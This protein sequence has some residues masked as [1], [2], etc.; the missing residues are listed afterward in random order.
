MAEERAEQAAAEQAVAEQASAEQ[1][2]PI[3]MDP[4]EHHR[5]HHS[6][7]KAAEPVLAMNTQVELPSTFWMQFFRRTK[8]ETLPKCKEFRAL[9][10]SRSGQARSGSACHCPATIAPRPSLVMHCPA[11]GPA[12]TPRHPGPRR[13]GP[14]HCQAM[15]PRAFAEAVMSCY[16]LTPRLAM[17]PRPQAP[18]TPCST[19]CPARPVVPGHARPMMLGSAT[20]AA[21]PMM[22]PA[23]VLARQVL[24]R[25]MLMLTD[26][27]VWPAAA[28]HHP[29]DRPTTPLWRPS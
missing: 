20:M 7:A 4:P 6:Q 18:M 8:H 17:T 10:V 22:R 26:R 5:P 9:C 16:A 19:L 1:A 21:K 28:A 3:A 15:T 12:M 29:P 2:M 23:G 14:M 27:G 13:P 11:M 25:M 24:A